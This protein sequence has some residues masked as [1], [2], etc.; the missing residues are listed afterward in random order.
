MV[1]VVAATMCKCCSA[2]P[3]GVP[4]A[5]HSRIGDQE[6]AVGDLCKVCD[7]DR[8]RLYRAFMA[9]VRGFRAGALLGF[10]VG[11]QG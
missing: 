7:S 2:V 8:L 6:V 5:E 4:W 1:Q 9:S 11:S 3:G 10:F